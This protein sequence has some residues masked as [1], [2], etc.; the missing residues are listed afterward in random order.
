MYILSQVLAG[1]GLVFTTSGRLFKKQE[2]NLLFNIIANVFFILS[3]LF[4]GA[5]AGMFGLIV[6]IARSIVF[7]FYVKNQWQKRVWLLILFL[8]LLLA[9]CF[10]SMAISK[11]FVL[12]EF[13]LVMAKGGLYTYASWQHNVKIFR[14]LSIVCCICTIA[15][16]LLK[17]G[18]I[19]ALAEGIAIIFIVIVIIVDYVKSKKQKKLKYQ[20]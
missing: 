14:W 6:S 5:Y 7:Y 16:D 8:A 19:N 20:Q 17:Q 13:L 18:Y 11:E 15:H 3:Y 10:L 12:I 2:N 1:V 9:S 4:L